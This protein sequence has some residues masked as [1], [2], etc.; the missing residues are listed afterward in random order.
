MSDLPYISREQWETVGFEGDPEDGYNYAWILVQENLNFLGQKSTL[1]QCKL[2]YSSRK[3]YIFLVSPKSFRPCLWNIKDLNFIYYPQSENF[4][5]LRTETQLFHLSSVSPNFIQILVQYQKI[6][7]TQFSLPNISQNIEFAG[8]DSS[9]TASK[10]VAVGSNR[11][12]ATGSL[13]D[14]HVVLTQSDKNRTRVS[15][16]LTVTENAF[17][18]V[19]ETRVDIKF[20]DIKNIQKVYMLSTFIVVY[21]KDNR[22]YEISFKNQNEADIELFYQTIDKQINQ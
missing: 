19:G 16:K 8:F 20:A 6:P 5:E 11:S 15:G 10:P 1:A 14:L 12:Q 21:M 7:H 13:S 3:K 18:V 22:R 9:S 17:K 2:F 4:L